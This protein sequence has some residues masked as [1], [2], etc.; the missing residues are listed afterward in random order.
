[1]KM[2]LFSS[3][4][5]RVNSTKRPTGGTEFDNIYIKNDTSIVNPV[6][7][8]QFSAREPFELSRYTYL[9][10][11]DLYYYVDDI[12]SVRNN[13]YELHC[14]LD[15][16]ATY[17]TEISNSQAFI[18]YS[19]SGYDVGLVDNRLSSN[20]NVIRKTFE[21]SPI[22]NLFPSRAG[23]LISYVG[24]QHADEGTVFLTEDGLNT[25]IDKMTDNAFAELFTDP[26]N[27]ISKMLGSTS[28]VITD[29]RYTPICVTAGSTDIVFAGGYDT[30]VS[31]QIP[32][33]SAQTLSILEIPWNF[34]DE[35]TGGHYDFR[36]RS[37][38]STMILYLPGYG[39]MQLNPDNY[40]GHN[41][42]FIN[43]E[44]DSVAG[45][46]TYYIEGLTKAT[47]SIS[48]PVK[49]S[50]SQSGNLLGTVASAI[51]VGASIATGNVA[52]G[53]ASGFG[54]VTSLLSVNPGS[55][56]GIGGAST[57]YVNDKIVLTMISHNTHVSPGSVA[58][59]YGR[60]TS[61]VGRIGDFGGFVQTVNASV[62]VN[63]GQDIIQSINNFLN[64]GV[65]IE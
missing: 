12:V 19:T 27:A 61:K 51:G 15:V 34:L 13:Q 33:R 57:I 52:T 1:M 56:G 24:D 22:R 63:A 17:K 7:V 6:I 48:F 30:G 58:N 29:A 49:I 55:I 31:G 10:I 28:D 32:L 35:Q 59:N 5:K 9:M 3:F 43:V 54:A 65:Y 46:I 11:N 4:S 38:F 18:L 40:I 36:N 21:T 14:S 47:C 23:Y 53:I 37:Q 39:C 64:G 41:Q 60:P 45:E 42:M 8:W 62:S 20:P 25:I 2:T 26:S 50:T 16:L 44:L